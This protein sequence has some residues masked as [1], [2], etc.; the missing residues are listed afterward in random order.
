MPFKALPRSLNDF[1][2]RGLVSAATS[3]HVIASRRKA[4]PRCRS[5]TSE[6]GNCMHTYSSCETVASPAERQLRGRESEVRREGT[7]SPRKG[8]CARKGKKRSAMWYSKITGAFNNRGG[9]RITCLH[10][11]LC[12]TC[13]HC[14]IVT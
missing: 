14:S 4:P 13:A 2:N 1:F 10:L 6:K 8:N 5:N 3:L 7:G 9:G 12:F 11:P